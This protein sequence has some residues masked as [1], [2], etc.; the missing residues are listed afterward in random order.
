MHGFLI[1]FGMGEGEKKQWNSLCPNF[2]GFSS[3]VDVCG[4]L[5][6][7]FKYLTSGGVYTRLCRETNQ[8][9]EH[10]NVL[11]VFRVDVHQ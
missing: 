9:C 3:S 7:K 8:I 11:L 2:C 10:N 5:A 4:L 1:F 6:V